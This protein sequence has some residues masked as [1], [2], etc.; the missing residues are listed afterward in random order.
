MFLLNIWFAADF[1]AKTNVLSCCCRVSG[2]FS[3]LE[4]CKVPFC[5]PTQFIQHAIFCLVGTFAGCIVVEGTC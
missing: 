3:D 5:H 1:I 2:V 4:T